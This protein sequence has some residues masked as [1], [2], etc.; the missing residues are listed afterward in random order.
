MWTRLGDI[1]SSNYKY[2]LN[3]NHNELSPESQMYRPRWT[4]CNLVLYVRVQPRPIQSE[5][6]SHRILFLFWLQPIIKLPYPESEQP[7]GWSVS[8]SAWQ[9]IW[10]SFSVNRLNTDTLTLFPT[11]TQHPEVLKIKNIRLS[12]NE[13]CETLGFVD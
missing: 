13:Y 3:T 11:C 7:L 8:P 2:Y 12:E 1:P 10:L 9:F 4:R 5:I 6:R